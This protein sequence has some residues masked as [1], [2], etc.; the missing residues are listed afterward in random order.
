VGKIK[1][2]PCRKFSI[3]ELMEVIDVFH[4]S[5]EGQ[6]AIRRILEAAN[7]AAGKRKVF[8]CFN[9]HHHIDGCRRINGIDYIHINSMS[10]FWMGSKYQHVRYSDEID[11]AYPYIK[12]TA[13]YRAPLFALVTLEADGAFRIEGTRSQWVGPSP[14]DLGYP[15]KAGS[16]ITPGI[17]DRR[18]EPGAP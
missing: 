7:R 17:A 13:P 5:E 12:Y 3:E 11:K 8:A 2:P 16:G 14:S 10:Y 18:V 1:R 6:A 4:V 15:V 9:G